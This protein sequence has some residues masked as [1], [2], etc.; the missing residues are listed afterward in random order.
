MSTKPSTEKVTVKQKVLNQMLQYI[1][2]RF[3]SWQIEM[4]NKADGKVW[5]T[6]ANRPVKEAWRFSLLVY[7]PMDLNIMLDKA[8]AA[9]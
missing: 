8:N 3:I 2:E 1:I 4:L 6:A 7:L 9:K 5:A